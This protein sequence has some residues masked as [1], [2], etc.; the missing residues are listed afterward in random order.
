MNSY[1]LHCK[2][3]A[4]PVL[5]CLLTFVLELSES[6]DIISFHFQLVIHFKFIDSDSFR[7][8][9]FFPL[10]KRLG[11]PC[12]HPVVDGL[13]VRYFPLHLQ[14]TQSGWSPECQI[15]SYA[16]LIDVLIGKA[17][18]KVSRLRSHSHLESSIFPISLIKIV[19]SIS[20]GRCRAL[21]SLQ[22]HHCV[23][24]LTQL[25]I[26]GWVSFLES[27]FYS[28]LVCLMTCL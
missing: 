22:T 24:S 3:L 21:W 14:L 15:F 17:I 16:L 12:E 27:T 1:L 25:A 7:G 11:L 8:I 2:H 18:F 13:P 28:V 6:P 26:L 20:G 9:D 5:F 10:L 19:S 4:I 23:V